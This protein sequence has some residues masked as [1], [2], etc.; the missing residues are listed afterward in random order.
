MIIKPKLIV[1]DGLDGCG[2][3]TQFDL[4]TKKL[5][6]NK[7]SCKP[8]SFPEYDKTSSTLVKMYLN[9]EISKNADDVNAFAA[10]S[11]YA[12]DRYISYKLFWEQNY[13]NG[14][15]ILA[16]RYVSSNAIHQMAKLNKEKWNDYLDWLEDY[17]YNRL[18]LPKP[19][20]IIFLDMPVE[21]SSK[22]ISSRYKGDETRR[23]I[24][25]ADLNYLKK[26]RLSALY[27]AKKCNW[28]IIE[29]NNGD[30]PLSIDDI[31]LLIWDS[32]S[33][34]IFK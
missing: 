14:D 28:D 12:A 9:G 22:L 33:D 11:F 24:H 4:L 17:E 8:I 27:A 18:E 13:K 23:D 2:K 25:E 1:I 19:D 7:I 16:S 32:V 29:C 34:I 15:I 31:S 10:S 26:C 5:D 20:K 21:I 3:S 30:S 6:E